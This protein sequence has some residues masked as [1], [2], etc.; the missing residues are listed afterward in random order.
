MAQSGKEKGKKE[1]PEDFSFTQSGDDAWANFVKKVKGTK[2]TPPVKS[3]GVQVAV[4]LGFKTGTKVKDVASANLSQCQYDSTDIDKVDFLCVAAEP[5]VIKKVFGLTVAQDS[6]TKAWSLQGDAVKDG[7]VDVTKLPKPWNTSL[8]YLVLSSETQDAL[9]GTTAVTENLIQ[10]VHTPDTLRKFYKFTKVH[11][12]LSPQIV[13]IDTAL[14]PSHPYFADKS[15]VC[16]AFDYANNTL[17]VKADEENETLQ[18]GMLVCAGAF[19][20][21]PKARIIYVERDK[22]VHVTYWNWL[23]RLIPNLP[24]YAII[25]MS[26]STEAATSVNLVSALQWTAM[27]AVVT[28]AANNHNILVCSQGNNLGSWACNFP[29]ILEDIPVIGSHVWSNPTSNPSQARYDNF[30][31]NH[32][33][34][35]HYFPWTFGTLV[36]NRVGGN[37]P[38]I[39]G[40]GPNNNYK[41]IPDGRALAGS[42]AGGWFRKPEHDVTGN[43]WTIVSH[44][45]ETSIATPQFAVILAAIFQFGTITHGGT[46]T[47][48][49]N[50]LTMGIVRRVLRSLPRRTFTFPAFLKALRDYVNGQNLATVALEFDA[51]AHARGLGSGVDERAFEACIKHF[52]AYVP[53]DVIVKHLQSYGTARVPL[54]LAAYLR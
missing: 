34:D 42:T 48:M 2:V 3:R 25:S 39:R 28:A 26:W 23:A 12:G 17:G 8:T 7:K 36:G 19:C 1:L 14:R 22:P 10:S 31:D 11:Q 41:D 20:A 46:Q 44:E 21:M 33:I 24:Q 30:G 52:S 45:G 47:Q 15:L 13:V 9:P 27:N 50:Y 51:T 54:G 40:T 37:I 32:E 49:R 38:Y 4:L 18:H 43:T 5:E 53:E 6:K 35:Y 29:K 16:C